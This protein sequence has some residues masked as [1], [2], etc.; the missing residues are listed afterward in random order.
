MLLL[1]ADP[2]VDER[3][4]DEHVRHQKPADGDAG[5]NEERVRH[6]LVVVVG[7]DHLD[8]QKREDRE[9]R[10]EFAGP[11]R[12]GRDRLDPSEQTEP[13]PDHLGQTVEDFG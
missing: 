8:A 2:D 6:C 1:P 4:H 10:Q 5:R 9:G 13:R 3:A 7:F 11:F 12:F